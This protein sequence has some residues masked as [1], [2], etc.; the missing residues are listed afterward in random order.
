MRDMATIL[1]RVMADLPVADEEL[2]AAQDHLNAERRRHERIV[3]ILLLVS[4]IVLAAVFALW[5]AK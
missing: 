4:M 2:K 1:R 3:N 5:V